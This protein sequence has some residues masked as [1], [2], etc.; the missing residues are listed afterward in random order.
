MRKKTLLLG[1]ARHL[2][3]I[4]IML[5]LGT[6]VLLSGGCE[7]SSKSGACP[8]GQ[9]L[10]YETPGC[11][12]AAKPVCGSAIQDAC[13][14]A[15]CSCKGETIS[16]CDYAPEPFSAFG[17]CSASDAGRSDAP[18]DLAPASPDLPPV[19]PDLLPDL[20][21]VSPDSMPDLSQASPDLWTDAPGVPL[22]AGV[23]PTGQVLRYETPGCGIAAAA[24][25]GSPTQDACY[26]AVCSCKGVT[27]SRC[28]FAPEPFAS[29][30][31]CAV[32]DGGKDGPSEDS[33]ADLTLDLS[34]EMPGAA[35]DGGACPAGQVLRYET[36][37]CGAA[38]KPVC[39]S[40]QQDACV[41][42]VCSCK[43][44]TISRCDYAPEPFGAFGACPASD[45]G[46]G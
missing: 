7:S 29:F 4:G 22:D 42:A 31:S 37:G 18:P 38:A 36:A 27:I 30:G 43:G 8:A 2:R 20:P 9:I 24:V 41:R 14:R 1:S 15:V 3:D 45:G 23:C 6:A 26:R 44:E 12:A 19:W 13:Y 10:R 33:P 25:C 17:V 5:S 16:R 21:P 28:D 40:P 32:L 39:G 35:W 34:T 11:G 46:R